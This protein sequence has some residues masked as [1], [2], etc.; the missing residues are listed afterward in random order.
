VISTTCH[1]MTKKTGTSSYLKLS[2][3]I[4]LTTL[5]PQD[6]QHSSLPL[7]VGLSYLA[8]I[9]L[10]AF[11]HLLQTTKYWP[12]ANIALNMFKISRSYSLILTNV[13]SINYNMRQ[14]NEM[15]T[16]ASMAL[17]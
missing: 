3:H 8:M 1:P 9:I 16:I 10:I 7:D 11:V 4:G 17:Q 6:S 2:L 12:S 15:I 5:A 14:V 13:C